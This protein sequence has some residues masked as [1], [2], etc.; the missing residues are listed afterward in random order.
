MG[1]HG[2]SQR[3][4]KPIGEEVK[5]LW[6]AYQVGD[7]S[8]TASLDDEGD[9]GLDELDEAEPLSGEDIEAFDGLADDDLGGK[10]I[11]GAIDVVSIDE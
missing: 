3:G 9:A 7:V 2:E 5:R 10:D 6:A 1:R 8:Q 4:I 11:R